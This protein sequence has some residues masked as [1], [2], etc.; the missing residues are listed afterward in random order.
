MKFEFIEV[1][2]EDHG[3]DFTKFS[4]NASTGLVVACEPFQGWLWTGKV[5]KNLRELKTG[6]KVTLETDEEELTIAYPLDR[7]SVVVDSDRIEFLRNE[8]AAVMERQ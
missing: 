2:F 7:C 1:E 6:I 3:Q 8:Q 5:V 4:I